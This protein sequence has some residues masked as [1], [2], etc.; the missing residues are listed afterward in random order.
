LHGVSWDELLALMCDKQR[1]PT[2]S[3]AGTILA[4][5]VALSVN[6]HTVPPHTVTSLHRGI[7]LP[8]EA[9]TVFQYNLVLEVVLHVSKHLTV[10]VCLCECLRVKWS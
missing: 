2:H 1:I 9:L 8:G 4:K 6:L 10:L 3:S 7:F 5:D